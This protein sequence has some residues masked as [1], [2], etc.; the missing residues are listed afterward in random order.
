M[1]APDLWQALYQLLS[2]IFLKEFKQFNVNLYMIIKNAKLMESNI[3]IDFFLE[4]TNFKDDSNAYVVILTNNK[5]LMKVK[6]KDN[7]K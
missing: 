4:Y 7:N 2:I 6:I 5:S 3:R 1:I